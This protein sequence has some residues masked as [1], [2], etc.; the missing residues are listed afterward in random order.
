MTD[1]QLEPPEFIRRY[2]FGVRSCSLFAKMTGISQSAVS[3]SEIRGYYDRRQWRRIK[4][5]ARVQGVLFNDEYFHKVPTDLPE[6][7][8]D[9]VVP[10]LE[11]T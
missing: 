4:A 5:L 2:I 7:P 9:F 3:A 1:K 10:M 11:K 8:E 6:N